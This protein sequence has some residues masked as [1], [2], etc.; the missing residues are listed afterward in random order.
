MP[1]EAGTPDGVGL[2][3]MPLITPDWK[4]DYEQVG[5]FG[6]ISRDL[7]FAAIKVAGNIGHARPDTVWIQRGK[8]LDGNLE[9]A[10]AE[11]RK[12]YRIVEEI[13]K[14]GDKANEGW[15]VYYQFGRTVIVEHTSDPNSVV[16]KKPGTAKVQ[17]PHFHVEIAGPDSVAA[18]GRGHA[19]KVERV[20]R[21]GSAS[22]LSPDKAKFNHHLYYIPLS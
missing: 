13:E 12:K 22:P 4:V 8:V 14:D 3:H 6:P 7:A 10:I 5:G 9:H 15:G 19:F 2:V 11:A 18:T 1:K 21:M 20:E 17:M 16:V